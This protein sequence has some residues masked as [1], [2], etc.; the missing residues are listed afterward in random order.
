VPAPD[1]P[2]G[3]GPT[4]DQR[5]F[6]P[7]AAG[8]AGPLSE[9]PTAKDLAQLRVQMADLR[10]AVMTRLAEVQRSVVVAVDRLDTELRA[11]AERSQASTVAAL[12]EDLVELRMALN[13]LLAAESSATD[14]IARLRDEGMLELRHAL[15]EDVAHTV[16]QAATAM[17]AVAAAGQ[18]KGVEALRA[19]LALFG[20][21]F[22][23]REQDGTQA[24]LAEVARLLDAVRDEVA[25]VHVTVQDVVGEADAAATE[26]VVELQAALRT[27]IEDANEAAAARFRALVADASEG[28]AHGLAQLRIAIGGAFER[29]QSDLAGLAPSMGRVELVSSNAADGVAALRAQLNEQLTGLRR[30]I[31]EAMQAE[32][33]AR[34]TALLQ[35]TDELSAKL[36]VIDQQQAAGLEGAAQAQREH[37]DGLRAVVTASAR[38]EAGIQAQADDLAALRTAS[39]SVARLEATTGAQ[40]LE[41]VVIIREVAAQVAALEAVVQGQRKDLE[42]LRAAVASAARTSTGPSPSEAVRPVIE[43]AVAD[44]RASL[45][46]RGDDPVDALRKE[47]GTTVRS[48]EWTLTE[49]QQNHQRM[50]RDELADALVSVSQLVVDEA[51][52][53]AT[54][55]EVATRRIDDLARATAQV[56]ATQLELRE[57]L[58]GIW[59]GG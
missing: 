42:A 39:T 37:L 16:D 51:K 29:L 36:T 59:G 8:G 54:E 9:P 12:N 57:L 48:L 49:A 30:V 53:R 35:A 15:V 2:P 22:S 7:V 27:V 20:V 40:H 44:L 32:T 24:G 34:E 50:L 3:S 23:Q 10:Q 14:S 45:E 38:L 4:P 19:E 5:L 26:R 58:L 43:A 47:L 1:R 33:R 17:Q 25:G 6:Q 18:D 11:T 56:A 41:H 52:S 46:Q 31:A 55:L 21:A 13:S 28:E